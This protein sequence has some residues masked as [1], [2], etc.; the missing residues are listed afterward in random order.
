MTGAAPRP[1]AVLHVD[2]DAFYASVEVLDDPSLRGTALIVGG[3]GPRGVVASCSYEARA[4][5]VRS[6]MSSVEARRRCPH[7]VF[8][9]G[10]HSRYGQVSAVIQQ[11]FASMT[12][13]VEPIALD[14][15]FLDVT[16]AQ[17]DREP[18]ELGASV[19]AAVADATGLTCSVGVATSKLIAKLASEAAKP[20]V[21]RPGPGP[22]AGQVV[23]RRRRPDDGRDLVGSTCRAVG[24][25]EVA[26]GDE[27]AFLHPHPARALWG[28]G[29]ATMQRLARFGVRT[30]GDIAALPR[31][32]LV[33]SLGDSLGMHLHRL[34]QAD[35]PRP[36]EPDRPTKSVGHEETFDRDVASVE[37]LH[38]EVIR[39]ADAVGGRL[40]RAGL[41]GRTVT[42]KVKWP[43]FTQTTRSRTLDRPTDG[44]TA[45][46]EVALALLHEP[47]MAARV[48]A[49]GVRL[50][51]VSVANLG[52]EGP[53]PQLSL[54]DQP[55]AEPAGLRGGATGARAAG[56]GAS[57]APAGD[58]RA[59]E[60]PG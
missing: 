25:V 60:P 18:W 37:E 42:L 52:E 51:G 32:T 53:A 3:E 38:V 17:R 34:S 45:I 2:M 6:A 21:D 15:A 20:V 28:V 26:A 48:V 49:Q 33:R 57:P 24:V 7:A 59:R 11:V 50:L 16:G 54:F 40:H 14:E 41:A 4:W 30:V 13:L 27:T 58:P 29:P 47:E 55:P 1:R 46:A 35:D 10:R 9:P 31:D 39:M 19:R 23:V 12:P 43:D 8:V 5:G 22:S 36:V 56:A 44:S